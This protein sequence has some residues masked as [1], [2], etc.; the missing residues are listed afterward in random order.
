MVRFNRDYLDDFLGVIR[1]Y[2][3]VRGALSQK[4]LA[5]LVG[6][7]ISTM[8]RFL[9]RK[10]RELDEQFIAKIVAR[11][12]I[13]LH[14]IIDFIEEDSTEQFKRL[15]QFYKDG[16]M[17][18][19]PSSDN[20]EEEDE[21]NDVFSSLGTAERTTTAKVKIGGKTRSIPFRADDGARNNPTTLR[22]KLERL[23]PRQKAYLSDFLELDVEGKDLVVDVGNSLFRYFRQ[24]GVEF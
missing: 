16:P 5:N 10:T 7:G 1:K 2:M 17:E 11:L 15:I 9:N 13:P 23:T 3:Q 6:V 18:P 20:E 4:D 24:K 19:P 8:S 22:D 12:N 21:F 14:E